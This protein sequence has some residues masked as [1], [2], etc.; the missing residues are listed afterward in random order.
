[1]RRGPKAKKA[2]RPASLLLRVVLDHE[3]PQISQH[4]GLDGAMIRGALRARVLLVAEQR[5]GR[6]MHV[7]FLAF[8]KHA[9]LVNVFGVFGDPVH[10]FDMHAC[11]NGGYL[12]GRLQ[13]G[14]TTAPTL[15]ITI[16]RP[17]ERRESRSRFRD[18]VRLSA[19]LSTPGTGVAA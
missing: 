14:R 19:R 10:A 11:A 9:N 4:G 18:V 7:H 13:A 12:H 6:V 1:M 16:R 15:A 2:K 8:A 5:G 17:R 3:P